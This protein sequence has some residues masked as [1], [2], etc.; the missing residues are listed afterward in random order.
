MNKRKPSA[1]KRLWYRLTGRNP[2]APKSKGKLTLSDMISNYKSFRKD[3]RKYNAH[4]QF[5]KKQR[6]DKRNKERKESSDNPLHQLF[7]SNE[8]TK[9]VMVNKDGVILYESS[10]FNS[11]L[12]IV[13]SMSSFLLAYVIVYLFYQLSVLFTASL[14]E[15]D[16][17]LYYYK[18][19]FNDHSELWGAFNIIIITLSGPMNSLIMGFVFYNYLY[20]KA[21]DYPRL[22]LFFLWTA[23]LFFAHFFAAFIAG[24]ITHKGFGYVPLWLFW[25]EFAKIF[26]AVVALASLLVLGHLSA[27]RFLA[28]SN[29]MY[30]I[31]KQKRGVFFLVQAV[32]PMVF[33]VL[34]LLVLKWPNNYTYDT[35]ILVFSIFIVGS[36]FFNTNA[37]LPYQILNRSNKT[38]LNWMLILVC[39]LVLYSFR[40]YLEDGLHFL[41]KMSISITPAG[42]EM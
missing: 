1:L 26:G 36:A 35:L 39:V 5:L 22:Q 11:F 19:D 13:N 24:I 18:L 29:H 3:K 34:F 38:Y 10:I 27:G 17:I 8:R 33:G 12:H 40:V 7:F 16:S 21:K 14:Y 6:K 23:L 4:Q 31:Q 30:R 28:T 41:I 32:L 15:I 20:F 25:S 2:Y 37:K 9:R 42:A